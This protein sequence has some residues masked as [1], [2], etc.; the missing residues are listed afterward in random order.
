MSY[1]EQAADADTALGYL[2][3]LAAAAERIAN[4]LDRIATIMD[5]NVR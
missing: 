1:P 2:E 3:R 5:E 4:L